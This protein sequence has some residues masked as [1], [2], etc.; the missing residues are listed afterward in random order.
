MTATVKALQYVTA[1]KK[2]LATGLNSMEGL[3]SCTDDHLKAGELVLGAEHHFAAR[4]QSWRRIK[5]GPLGQLQTLQEI[6]AAKHRRR[7]CRQRG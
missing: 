4:I 2:C 6:S 5:I 3:G 1:P 7:A